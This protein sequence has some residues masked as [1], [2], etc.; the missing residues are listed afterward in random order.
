MLL[1]TLFWYIRRIYLFRVYKK[2][3]SGR[4]S[5]G[6][7]QRPPKGG[8]ILSPAALTVYRNFDKICIYYAGRWVLCQQLDQVPIYETAI[9]RFQSFAINIKNRFTSQKME[10]ETWRS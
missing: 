1:S 5:F 10:P 2:R 3:P 9:T 6:K 8:H 4:F 7:I